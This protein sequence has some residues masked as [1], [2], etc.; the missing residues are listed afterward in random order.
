[1]RRDHFIAWSNPEADQRE[2]QCAGATRDADRMSH[3]QILRKL[4][5]KTLHPSARRQYGI[6]QHFRY[7]IKLGLAEVVHEKR[8]VLH[9]GNVSCEI[10]QILKSC[11]KLS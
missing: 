1:R 4:L 7:C 3:L 2:V 8:N 5:L 6:R 11:R 10:L 9:P